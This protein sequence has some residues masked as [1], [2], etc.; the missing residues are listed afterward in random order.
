MSEFQYFEWQAID[1]LLTEEELR[2]VH[3]LSSHMDVVTATQAVVTY[4]W[5]DFKHDPL[6]VLL[7]YF[8][9]M[10]YSANW[11][12]RRLAFRFPAESIDPVRIDAYCVEDWMT[13][14]T[15]GEHYLLDVSL[16]EEEFRGWDE[17]P[18]SLTPYIHLRQQIIDGDYRALYLAWLRAA[19]AS[20]MVIE[21]DREPPVPAGLQELDGSLRA[22]ARSF[23]QLD[24]RLLQVA[25]DASDPSA[26]EADEALAGSLTLLSLE[27]CRAYL[28]RVLRNEPQVRAALRKR[29]GDLAG[30]PPSPPKTPRTAG[31]LLSEAERLRR[32]EERRTQE[33]AERKR[34]RELEALAR[35]K[36]AVWSEVEA[37]IER[38][39][40]KSYQQAVTL[41]KDLRD[42]AVYQERLFEFTTRVR[43]IREQHAR[44]PSLIEQLD[45]AGL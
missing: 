33:A 35:R 6:K 21:D 25:A 42:L 36:E 4:H 11:G 31:A 32:Q 40:Y 27:E 20:T 12:S 38:K 37:Q 39:Q 2:Q 23:L 19:E 28:Q 24:P 30:R 13:L 29:L 26:P 44:R 9:A 45:R 22:F 14:E 10:L 16:Y 17:Q 7:R 18:E 15:E 5:G 41:L 34:I 3:A 1:N 43:E 8:D